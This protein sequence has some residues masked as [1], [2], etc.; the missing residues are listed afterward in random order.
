MVLP[1]I[2]M[3]PPQANTFPIL[4][5][6]LTSL[7]AP[8]L[9]SSYAWSLPFLIVG[10]KDRCGHILSQWQVCFLDPKAAKTCQWTVRALMVHG[11]K[12]PHLGM[13]R[14]R[15]FWPAPMWPQGWSYRNGHKQRQLSGTPRTTHIC[16]LSTPPCSFKESSIIW[17]PL[18]LF[19]FEPLSPYSSQTSLY[20]W[21]TET[22]TTI[23]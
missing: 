22:E 23:S 8:S 1:H 11:G 17:P 12:R 6:P 10:E 19:I 4:N 15:V 16:P 20:F 13:V 14:D 2:N 3:N 7:P 21:D 5:S 9:G 18:S